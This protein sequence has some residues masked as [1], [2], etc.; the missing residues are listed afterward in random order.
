VRQT[1]NLV[2]KISV[3]SRSAKV[4]LPISFAE[5]KSTTTDRSLLNRWLKGSMLVNDVSLMMDAADEIHYLTGDRKEQAE[6]L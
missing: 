3:T 5:R 1:H 6:G 4:G 2:R